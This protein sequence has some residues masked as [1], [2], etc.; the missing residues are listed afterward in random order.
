M[1]LERK[2]ENREKILVGHKKKKKKK[3][4]KNGWSVKNIGNVAK[5]YSLFTYFFLLMRYL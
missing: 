5:T 3:I 1:H 4:G 2:K